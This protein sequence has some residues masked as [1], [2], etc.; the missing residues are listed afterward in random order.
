M[1]SLW[2]TPLH[3]CERIRVENK[4]NISIIYENSLTS[5]TPEG[6]WKP[7][8]AQDHTLRT[9]LYTTIVAVKDSCSYQN[10]FQILKNSIRS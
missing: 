7:S 4:S 2:K 9:H 6:F 1:G 5:C 8:G 3:A 10:S